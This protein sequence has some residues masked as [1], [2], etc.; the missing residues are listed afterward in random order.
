M[1]RSRFETGIVTGL[2]RIE[3]EEGGRDE[4][5]NDGIRCGKRKKKKG[6]D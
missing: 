1:D 2:D 3:S 4:K 6:V 5:V